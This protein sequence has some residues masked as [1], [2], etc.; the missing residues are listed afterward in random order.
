M[1]LLVFVRLVGGVALV[2]ACKTAP[3]ALE[4]FKQAAS[5]GTGERAALQSRCGNLAQIAHRRTERAEGLPDLIHYLALEAAA[6]QAH[7]IQADHGIAFRGQG[8]RRDVQRDACAATDHHALA[9]AAEL[10][11]DRTAAEKGP[12]ADLHMPGQQYRIGD[13]NTIAYPAIVRHMAGGHQKAIRTNLSGRAG[14]GGTT[15]RDVFAND[16]ARANAYT[17]LRTGIEA[18]V[19]RIATDHGEWMNH[20][21]FTELTMP[22]DQGVGMDYTAGTEPG[23]VVDEGSRM[24]LHRL[25]APRGR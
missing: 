9:D 21:P 13:N 19:L 7:D 5:L 17:G 8:K 3:S 11:D 16:S 24:N 6:P 18:Q 22:R 4:E 12:I 1:V 2:Y 15:D 10:V 23:T 14:P 20:D 25:A